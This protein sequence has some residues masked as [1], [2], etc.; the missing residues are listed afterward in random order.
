MKRL[1]AM[2]FSLMSGSLH[3][4]TQTCN[5]PGN[6]FGYPKAKKA[7]TVFHLSNG[8]S[9]ALCGFKDTEVAPGRTFYSEFVLAAC[10]EDHV[11]KF[12]GAVLDCQLRVH[13]DTL[14][15]ETLDSLPT[16]E[17][18][19]YKWTVWAIERIYFKDGKAVNDF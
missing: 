16:G 13:K 12:W 8:K 14:I 5:C 3:A 11:I 1:L 6:E 9:I 17:N 4:Q 7:D 2:L 19:R 10:G 18:M 15:V